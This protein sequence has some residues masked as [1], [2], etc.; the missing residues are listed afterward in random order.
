[1]SNIEQRLRKAHDLNNPSGGSS[2]YSKAADEIS[3]LRQRIKD[4][5]G[6]IE[7]REQMLEQSQQENE[8]L[9]KANTDCVAWEKACKADLDRALAESVQAI[10][11]KVCGDLP[12]SWVV[13]LCMENGAA[14]VEAIKPSGYTIEIDGADMTLIEQINEAMRLAVE[15]ER[16]Q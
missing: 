9:R 2:I 8:A 1:M 3:T 13:N 10:A 16:N 14:W 5:E 7:R 11:N 6:A 12:E 4:C 15:Q